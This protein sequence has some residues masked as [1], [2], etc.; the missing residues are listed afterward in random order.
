[1]AKPEF[2]GEFR[3][4]IYDYITS[5]EQIEVILVLYADA[6]RSWTTEGMSAHLRANEKSIASRLDAL[7]RSG[8]AVTEPAGAYRYAATGPLNEMVER[9]KDEYGLRRFS[10][11]EL[12][13]S[14]PEGA[15]SF[16]DA[17]RLKE[18]E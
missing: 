4:F 9:L 16:A 7:A 13:F 3:Q 15:R 8:F 14:R 12:V 6:R 1:M 2:S 18:D 10:L 5:V 11:I 17:F